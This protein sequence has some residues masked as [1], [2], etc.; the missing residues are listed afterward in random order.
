[1]EEAPGVVV[2]VMLDA[3]CGGSYR[4]VRK[5]G[6]EGQFVVMRGAMGVSRRHCKPIPTSIP[7]FIPTF[8]PTIIPIK[9]LYTI[10]IKTH[11]II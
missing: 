8:I 1:M 6:V 10:S 7:T 3:F 9:I 11:T 2:V 4:G 5:A